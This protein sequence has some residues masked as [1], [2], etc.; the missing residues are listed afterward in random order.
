MYI[1]NRSPGSAI[2]FEVPEAVWTGAEPRYDHLRRFGCISYVHTLADKISPR[3]RKGVLL[4]YALGTKGYRVWLLDE[5]K[6]VVSKDVVFN[7]DKVYKQREETTEVTIEDVKEASPKKRVT[8]KKELE[9][10]EPEDTEGES[11]TQGGAKSAKDPI[12]HS[13]SSDSEEEENE[14]STGEGSEDL[15]E[16]ILAR[17]RVRRQIRAPSKFGDNDLVAYALASAKEIETEE[18]WSYAEARR[19]KDWKLWNGA[20]SE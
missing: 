2:D 3:P 10:F 17:D 6:V 14:G 13:D 18:P 5:E 4:G 9:E 8:F 7:E 15:S 11:S 19:S 16:Y 20:M 1:I 12:N